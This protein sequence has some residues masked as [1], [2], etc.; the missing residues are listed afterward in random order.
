MLAARFTGANRLVVGE[1]PTPVCPA[2]GLLVKVNACAI[3]GTDVKTLDKAD[4]KLEGGKPRSMNLPRILGHELAGEVAE[5]GPAASG[6]AVGDRVVVAPTVPCGDCRYCRRGAAEMCDHL[7]VFGYDWDGGFSELMRVEGA[8]LRAGC[9]ISIPDGLDDRHACLAEPISC[10]LN[11]LELSPVH[12]GDTVAVIGAGPLGVILS[13]LAKQRGA[14]A[15]LLAE[16]SAEQI[17]AARVSPADYLIH[18]AAEDLQARIETITGGHGV[19]V[20]IVACSAQ[21]V[22]TDALRLIAKRGRINLFAGLPRG[23]SVVAWDTNVI[24]YSECCVTGTH[25]SRPE[26]VRAALE[27]LACGTLDGEKLVSR[28]F[29]LRAINDALDY[30]RGVGRLKV[31]ITM[32]SER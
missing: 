6:F 31:V 18:T 3:C 32:S 24:H 13:T 27:L 25:G 4:V 23:N 19:D 7:R 15:V 12:P 20:L 17:A 28:V 16:R 1:V 14:G 10:A 30:C 2:E 11:C 26:H 5:C 8:V 21:Q 22:Q 9:V 29:P